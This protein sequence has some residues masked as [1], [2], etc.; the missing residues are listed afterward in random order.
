MV[1]SKPTSGAM[2]RSA[3]ALEGPPGWGDV[4]PMMTNS[5]SSFRPPYAHF[6]MIY[7][8][9]DGKLKVDESSSI[10]EQNSTVFTP[11]VR[12]NF[13]EILGER[14]G[15]HAPIRQT[16]DASPRRVRRRKGNAPALS[17]DDRLTEQDTDSE[18]GP[19]GSTEMVPLRIGDS[20][21]VM[22]YYEGA[23]KHFQ[24]LNCRMVAKAFIKFIEPRKQVR[25]PYNGGKPP[26]GS[27]PGTTGDPEKTKPEW[28]PP[29]VMHK[30]P[31][32]LRKEY[33]IELLLHIIRKLG[34]YGITAEKLKDVAGDTKRSLKHPSHVEIIYEILRVR[35]MEERF[36]RGEVDA[37]MVVYTMNRGPS[38][39]GDEEDDS[40]SSVTIEEPEHINQGLMTPISS[41]EQASTSLTTPIDNIQ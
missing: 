41:F 14:I 39:K 21:K 18:E 13:L 4:P 34:S 15:Y 33:R 22:A 40:T 5:R 12:Q 27:A 26:A 35:K 10:Q 38:P 37:N 1:Y 20:Q 32:H 24:Q 7:L 36:E 17:V 2:K 29:G 25:H 19:S 3:S 31:D 11:E 9:R 28:W 8:D 6:A 16:M 30:E 23:L